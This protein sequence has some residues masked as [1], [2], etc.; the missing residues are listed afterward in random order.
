MCYESNDVCK[1]CSC[2]RERL[3]PTNI[4]FFPLATPGLRGAPFYTAT[5]TVTKY[6]EGLVETFTCR[7]QNNICALGVKVSFSP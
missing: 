1:I 2:K 5:M 6:V 7:D 3:P 4:C